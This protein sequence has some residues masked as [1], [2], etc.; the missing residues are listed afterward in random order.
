EAILAR[1]RALGIDTNALI[2]VSHGR[3]DPSQ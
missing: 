1:A 2:S 3:Q